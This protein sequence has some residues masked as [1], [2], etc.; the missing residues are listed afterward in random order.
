M[1]KQTVISETD[2]IFATGVFLKPVNCTIDGKEQWRWV[3][4]GFEDDSYFNG[5]RIDIFD[6]ADALEDLIA[7]NKE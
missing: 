4:V 5:E 1:D 2:K 6:Y 3:A 7:E